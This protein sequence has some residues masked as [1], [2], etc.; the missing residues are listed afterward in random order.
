MTSSDQ[1]ISKIVSFTI[2]ESKDS[3]L[4][5]LICLNTEPAA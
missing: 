2:Y 3:L 5:C 1:D 4:I